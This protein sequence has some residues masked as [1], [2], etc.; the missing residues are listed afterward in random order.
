ME[1]VTYQEHGMTLLDN[2]NFQVFQGEIMGLIP[3]DSFGLEEF[4]SLLKENRPIFYGYVYIKEKLVNVFGASIHA[5]NNIQVISDESN[6]VKYISAADN[7]FALRRGYKGILTKRKV[8]NQQLQRIMGELNLSIA[9]EK[10]LAKMSPFEKYVIEILK[11]IINNPDV[12]VLKDMSSLLNMS[13]LYKLHEIIRHYADKGYTFI[14]ISL[15][16]EE[17]SSVCHRISLM[18]QGGI[19]KVI[20]DVK[21]MD[22]VLKHYVVPKLP[23][24]YDKYGDDSA[25]SEKIFRCRHLCYKR[26]HDLSFSVKRGECLILYDLCREISEDLVAVLTSEKLDFERVC[27]DGGGEKKERLSHKRQISIILENPTSSMLYENMSYADNLCI[28]LD[29]KLRGIWKDK[30]KRKSIAKEILGEELPDESCLVK[31]LSI[32]Q[33]YSLIYTRVL[34]QRPQVIFCVYPYLNVDMEIQEYIETIL[35]KFLK[36]GIAVVIITIN[37]QDVLHMADRLVIVKDGVNH[38][39]LKKEEFQHLIHKNAQ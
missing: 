28:T 38:G 7:V 15:H 12:I 36:E 16:K 23:D 30:R 1:R 14:Y 20:E 29:H 25:A 39:A 11:A 31:D 35:K 18:R 21:M 22:E 33:K 24:I 37:F 5:E 10:P 9:V 13:D 27:W 6:L 19:V 2:F 26:I 34:L 32:K 17:L 8:F 4:I 3:L